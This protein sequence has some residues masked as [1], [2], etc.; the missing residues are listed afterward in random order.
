MMHKEIC[1]P[2]HDKQITHIDLNTS[3]LVCANDVPAYVAGGARLAPIMEYGYDNAEVL[4][5]IHQS[6]HELL[7]RLENTLSYHASSNPVFE[8][9]EKA[10]NMYIAY[11]QSVKE[12]LILKLK[13]PNIES[14]QNMAN[15]FCAFA[16]EASIN[17]IILKKA[18]LNNNAF[19]IRK[20]SLNQ[21]IKKLQEKYNYY[22]QNLFPVNSQPQEIT[23]YDVLFKNPLN[24]ADNVLTHVGI[25]LVGFK[26][27]NFNQ[28]LSLKDQDR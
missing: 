18:L 27:A 8:K 28:V 26:P 14:S 9:I 19:E 21:T 15:E 20:F 25:A 17:N 1:N 22:I 2:A 12:K 13:K 3:T 11:V 23:G 24:N 6:T 4:K 16:E 5:K 10:F 7:G